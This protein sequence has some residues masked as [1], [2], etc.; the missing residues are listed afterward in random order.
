MVRRYDETIV[1]DA[2]GSLGFG[3][4]LV[5]PSGVAA[6]FSEAWSPKQKREWHIGPKEFYPILVAAQ[7]WGVYWAGKRILVA[8]D[9]A[10]VVS[11]INKGY[12]KQAVLGRMLRALT[13]YSLKFNFHLQAQHVPGKSN[14]IADQLSRLQVEKFLHGNPDCSGRRVSIIDTPN[15]LT[16]CGLV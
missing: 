10:T 7:H 4:Y 16:D 1:T 15:P 14:I 11:A 8:C 2:A 12:S 9:N 13:F 5:S 6:W 3:G